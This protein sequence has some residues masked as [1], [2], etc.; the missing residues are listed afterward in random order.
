MFRVGVA[1]KWQDT[2]EYLSAP[3]E[4][5]A[6]FP[7][8]RSVSGLALMSRQTIV[9]DR[10][11]MKRFRDKGHGDGVCP[12]EIEQARGLDEIDFLSYIAIPIISRP[13]TS[14]ANPLGV[15]TIDSKLFVAPELKDPEVLNLKEGIFRAKLSPREL[16]GYANRLYEAEDADVKYIEQVTK[17][18]VPVL[19]LYSKCRVGA[20]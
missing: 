4:Y 11:R 14:T 19:E 8:Q 18:I 17:M 2:L 20:T 1:A 12:N 16:T 10:D 3:G 9:M 5:R 6:P 15:V 7:F 13:D